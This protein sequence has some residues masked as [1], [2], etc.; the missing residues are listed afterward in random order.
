MSMTINKPKKNK[1]MATEINHWKKNIDANFISGEDLHD[2]IKGLR[3][4]MVVTFSREQ[5]KEAFDANTSTKKVVTGMFLIDTT[6]KSEIPKPLVMNKANGKFLEKEFGTP[7][8][9]KW[10]KDKPF[11]LYCMAHPRFNWVARLRKYEKPAMNI[12]DKYF[13]ACRALYLKSPEK[14]E[15]IKNKYTISAEVEAELIK[16]EGGKDGK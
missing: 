11:I 3:P 16:P 13:I 4:E 7:D 9:D 10:P 5:N 12:G 1:T 15:S 6:T 8:M 14:L 2:S